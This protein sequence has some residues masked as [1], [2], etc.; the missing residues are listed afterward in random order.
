[1]KP[2]SNIHINFNL[3]ALRGFA[4]LMVVFNHLIFHHQYFNAGYFPSSLNGVDTAAHLCVLIFFVLSGYVI[5][6]SQKRQLTNQ[7][8]L[9]Y[10]K[11]RFV[12]LYPIYFIIICLTLLVTVNHYPITTIVSNFSFTQNIFSAPMFECNPIWS[13]NYEVLY[14]LLFIP[15]SYFNFNPVIVLFLSIACA[16]LNFNSATPIISSYL[17]GFSFW[18]TGLIMARYMRK[19]EKPV[20][21][22]RLIACF[23]FIW[24]LQD[25][26]GYQGF[27]NRMML[28]TFH[29]PLSYP[30]LTFDNY[31]K[32]MISI[33]DLIFL[34]YAFLIVSLFA[35]KTIKYRNALVVALVIFP[36]DLLLR[37]THSK[38]R[39]IQLSSYL[40]GLALYFFDLPSIDKVS[41]A[42][43]KRFVVLGSLS[44]ALYVVHFPLFFLF[45]RFAVSTYWSYVLKLSLYLISVLG[46][47]YLLEIKL[48]PAF[49]QLAARQI[50]TKKKVLAEA[51]NIDRESTLP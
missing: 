16:I 23:L 25:L 40:I 13:L 43:I 36:I 46:I 15:I 24:P 39:I 33:N 9:I 19:E 20:K 7:T 51:V 44:Y 11:K 49:K 28:R 31:F 4:A 6:T 26:I 41:Q 18:L 12:R 47:S 38:L 10:L 21:F 32:F 45:D 2:G 30:R 8:I 35:G 17:F 37:D 14:Y 22:S 27:V 34:L 48:Q 50:K 5:G 29:R 1:M 42:L 3:E